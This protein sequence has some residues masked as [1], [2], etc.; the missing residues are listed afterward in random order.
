MKG[1]LAAC[2]MSVFVCVSVCED[3]VA[4]VFEQLELKKQQRGLQTWKGSCGLNMT[5]EDVIKMSPC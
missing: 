2:L 4:G 1:D 5:S 3:D